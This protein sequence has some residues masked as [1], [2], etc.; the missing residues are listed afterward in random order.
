MGYDQRPRMIGELIMSVS[1][2]GPPH[3]RV[4]RERFHVRKTL[5]EVLEVIRCKS[6]W[7]KVTDRCMSEKPEP[8]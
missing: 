3:V 8:S 7:Q 1:P 2:A 6:F 5:E 4:R